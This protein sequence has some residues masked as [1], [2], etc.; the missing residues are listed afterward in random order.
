MPKFEVKT[1]NFF[2]IFLD[3][4]GIN[5]LDNINARL[6]YFFVLLTF[7]I[8]GNQFSKTAAIRSRRADSSRHHQRFDAAQSSCA[9]AVGD[10]QASLESTGEEEKK[11][12]KKQLK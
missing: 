9:A 7:L 12:G 10:N 2:F 6:I 8:G 11:A 1:L 4:I 5:L 3:F